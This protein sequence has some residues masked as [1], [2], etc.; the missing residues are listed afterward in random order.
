MKKFKT[1]ED[2]RP[3][4]SPKPNGV[5]NNILQNIKNINM[6]KI[7]NSIK[8]VC[9]NTKNLQK[10]YS[11]EI[12]NII[13]NNDLK[14]NIKEKKIPQK[15]EKE[16]SDNDEY[17][18][19]LPIPGT[20]EIQIFN[21]KSGLIIKRNVKFNS[22]HKYTYFLDGCRSILLNDYLYIFG[23]ISKEKIESK[24]AYIYYVK[25]N[26]LSLLPEMN[27]SHS[28]HTLYYLSNYNSILVVGGENNNSCELFNIK[29]YSWVNLPDMICCKANCNVYY[30]KN[31]EIIYTFFGKT[32]KITINNNYLDA[33]EYI[34]LREY[35]LE[36]KKIKYKNKSGMNLKNEYIKI[37]PFSDDMI[38]I[39]GGNNG[40]CVY[41]FNKK[42]IVKFDHKIFNQITN[43]CKNSEE[44]MKILL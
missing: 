44:L 11:F 37:I 19:V 23:G 3:K 25:S 43:N 40:R 38:I 9:L 8:D 15:S 31:N 13:N 21:K 41:L 22:N 2:F 39:N 33:I 14:N 30:D 24:M 20:N 36:W 18:K 35:P 42:E 10:F 28:Y 27:N 12:L 32:G 4:T 6:T 16:E 1:P 26:E 5:N 29:T 34:S 17:D 7:F